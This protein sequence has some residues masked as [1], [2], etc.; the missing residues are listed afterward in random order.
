MKRLPLAESRLSRSELV[1]FFSMGLA[2]AVLIGMAVS[3]ST[4]LLPVQ[5][6]TSAVELTKV[7]IENGGHK[8]SAAGGS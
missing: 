6:P 2:A 4:R 1:A 8:L 5:N 7:P 3:T